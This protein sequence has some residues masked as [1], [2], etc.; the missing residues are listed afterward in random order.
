MEDNEKARLFSIALTLAVPIA[1]V[2]GR[3]ADR[4]DRPFLP[5]I[6]GASVSALGLVGMALAADADGATI[7]YLLF[8]IA[9]TVCLSLHSGQTPRLLPRP[10]PRGRALGLPHLTHTT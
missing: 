10:D 5:L 7:A 4:N 2:A 9:T 3:W 6:V 1:L 8:G